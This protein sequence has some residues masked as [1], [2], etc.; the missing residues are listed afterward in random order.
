MRARRRYL[1]SSVQRRLSDCTKGRRRRA[2]T[3]ASSQKSENIAL[4][5]TYLSSGR[6][7]RDPFVVERE[8]EGVGKAT[9]KGDTRALLRNHTRRGTEG[10]RAICRPRD[11]RKVGTPSE[12]CAPLFVTPSEGRRSWGGV[13]GSCERLEFVFTAESSDDGEA[14]RGRGCVR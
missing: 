6:E 4:V 7:M 13:S 10:K 9:Q 3:R 11:R 2:K 12:R 5:Y 1:P 8:T 14:R